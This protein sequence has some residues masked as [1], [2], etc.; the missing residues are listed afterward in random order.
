MFCEFN[1]ILCPGGWFVFST[2]HPFFSYGC[3]GIDDYFKTMQV[4]SQWKGFGRPVDVPSYFH[5]LGTIAGALASSGFLTERIVDPLPMQ[6]LKNADPAAYERLMK[7]PL[8]ICFR[9]RKP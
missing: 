7:F 2:E 4:H 9:A 5:S 6:E 3:F 8:F 1:C